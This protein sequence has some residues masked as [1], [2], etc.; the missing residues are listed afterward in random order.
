M[1]APAFPAPEARDSGR[2]PVLLRRASAPPI[3]RRRSLTYAERI[4]RPESARPP[5]QGQPGRDRRGDQRGLRQPQ[6]IRDAVRRSL[7]R[8]RYGSTTPSKRLKGWMKPAP[9]GRRPSDLRRREQ[10]PHSAAARRGRRHR[11]VE[12]PAVPEL[13]AARQHLRRRQPGDGENVGEFAPPGRAADRDHAEILPRGKARVLRRR[14]RTRARLLVAAVRPSPVHR[15]RPDRPGGDGQRCAQPDAGD[16]RARRQ[17]A[18][19]RSAGLS[20]QDRRRAHPV[21]QDVQRGPDVP[22]GR[23]P[24]PAARRRERRSSIIANA[25]SPS[26]TRTSTARTSPRSSTSGPTTG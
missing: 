26:A 19:D 3:S 5:G 6:R 8:A 17:V 7:R 9:S 24:L 13:L 10:P 23:H 22:G 11:A 16:A 14:R 20:D 15:L 1:N 12:L 21:G 25:C 4:A 18:G 2:I